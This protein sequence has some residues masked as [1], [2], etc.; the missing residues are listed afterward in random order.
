M[1]RHEKKSE[2]YEFAAEELRRELAQEAFSLDGFNLAELGE[3][4][5]LARIED[6]L[7]EEIIG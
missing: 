3:E 1:A 2:K 4:R 6:G 5:P 7:N